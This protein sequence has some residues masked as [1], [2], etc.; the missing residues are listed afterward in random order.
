MYPR[1]RYRCA[2]ARS[3]RARSVSRSIDRSIPIGLG[4]DRSVSID[5]SISVSI[6]R[7]PIETVVT[8]DRE[9]ATRPTREASVAARGRRR[10]VRVCLSTST[11]DRRY[12]LPRVRRHTDRRAR[13]RGVRGRTRILSFAHPSLGNPRARRFARYA[14]PDLSADRVREQRCE[15][16]CDRTCANAR[17]RTNARTRCARATRDVTRVR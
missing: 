16:R 12:I 13:R 6:D 17:T 11:D 3:V 4:L 2:R 14:T 15:W 8:D 7:D 10:A 5:R 1:C 9:C